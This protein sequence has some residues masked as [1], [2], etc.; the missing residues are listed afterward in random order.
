MI[1]EDLNTEFWVIS[2]TH[3]I[4]KS[5]HDE[6]QAFSQMQKTSQGKDLYYSRDCFDSVYANGTKKKAC[7][8]YCYGG[9]YF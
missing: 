1:T 9:Y 2:D 6:G 3:L 4:A 5:L 7:S 8:N